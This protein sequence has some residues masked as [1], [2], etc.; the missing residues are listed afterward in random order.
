MYKLEDYP[1]VQT[2]I[3]LLIN[4]KNKKSSKDDILN[5]PTERYKEFLKEGDCPQEVWKE[6]VEE[7]FK[8]YE[9]IETLFA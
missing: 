1:E 7:F 5:L 6:L 4:N 9:D 2:Y 8:R 3:E